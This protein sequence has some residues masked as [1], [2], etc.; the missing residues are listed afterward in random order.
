M[1]DDMV[2]AGLDWVTD[3]NLKDFLEVKN[4]S[5]NCYDKAMAIK[6]PQEQNTDTPQ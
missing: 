5:Q 2:L 4:I 6:H 3:Q 1:F